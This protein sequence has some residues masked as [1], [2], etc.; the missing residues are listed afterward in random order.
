MR[1]RI[2]GKKLS[3]SSGHRKALKR[4]LIQSFFEHGELRTTL[5]K[6]R[7]IR[8]E[9]EKIITK[10]KKAQPHT[11]K[12]LSSF[13]YKKEV[14]E[15][16]LDEIA[17]RY[18]NRPGGYTRIIKLGPRSGDNAEMAIIQLVGG[19]SENRPETK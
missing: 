18:Q 15:K 7:F 12:M 1:K 8:P 13:F 11:Q 3:R 19:A 9:T 4:N 10:A 6:A 2:K 14:V 5:A 16:L 17:P